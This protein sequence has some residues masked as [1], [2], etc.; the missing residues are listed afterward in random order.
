MIFDWTYN[1]MKIQETHALT[2]NT[3]YDRK[4]FRGQEVFYIRYLLGLGWGREEIET[5]WKGLSGGTSEMF[6]YDEDQLDI[7]FGVLYKKA[8]KSRKEGRLK[9]ARNLGGTYVTLGEIGYLSRLD[10]PLWAK[11]YWLGVL[12]WFRANSPYYSVLRLNRLLQGDIF[13][14]A[15]P[16]KEFWHFHDALDEL[17]VKCGRPV[18]MATRAG[19]P[20]HVILPWMER[21]PDKSDRIIVCCQE[22]FVRAAALLSNIRVCSECGKE[23]E[24]PDSSKR[25]LCDS[26]YKATR[27]RK[28]AE[29]HRKESIRDGKNR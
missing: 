11:R 15:N 6:S 7:E 2:L 12:L 3:S 13:R 1:C 4:S 20:A 21:E 23:Y 18:R 25:T 19:L 27:H 29:C 17:G 22:D 26:C 5:E 10:A 24:A 9:L 16:G 14:T 28:Q 8:G